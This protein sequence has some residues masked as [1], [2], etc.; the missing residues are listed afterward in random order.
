MTDAL[1]HLRAR[2]GD[3]LALVRATRPVLTELD[4]KVDERTATAV[5]LLLAALDTAEAIYALLLQQP[6]Q[7][8]VAALVMQRSQMEYVLRA[9][10]FAKA[11]SQRELMAFRRTGAMPKRGHRPIHLTAVAEEAGQHLGWDTSKLLSTVRN[12]QRDLSGLVHGGKE[13]LAIYTQHD[14]WGDLTVEWGELAHHVDNIAVFTQ[15][16]LSVAML[17]SPLKPDALDRAVRAVHGQAMTYFNAN[18]AGA[19]TAAPPSH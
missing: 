15:L 3:A 17:L 2:T 1:N 11:A 6:D 14:A 8:W 19:Q 4:I 18:H 16:A 5:P 9:A 7:Y 13:V 12:H 10:F